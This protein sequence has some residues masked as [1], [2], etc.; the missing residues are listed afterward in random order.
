LVPVWLVNLKGGKY[1]RH[2]QHRSLNGFCVGA[3]KG[4]TTMPAHHVQHSLAAGIIPCF[5]NKLRL[6]APEQH[7]FSIKSITFWLKIISIQ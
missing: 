5:G 4:M 6:I 2:Y 1:P 7:I 3:V